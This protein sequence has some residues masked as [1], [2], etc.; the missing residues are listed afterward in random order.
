LPGAAITTDAQFSQYVK[1]FMGVAWHP[2]G[3]AA[4][5]SVVHANL[6][7]KGASFPLPVFLSKPECNVGTTNVFVV[8]GSIIPLQPSSHPS[9]SV[10]SIDSSIF[11][12]DSQAIIYGIGEKAAAMLKAFPVTNA[13]D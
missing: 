6:M 1:D 11:K 5:G 3:T 12:L 2:L 13:S 9:V 10:T 8:D 4:I 7:V